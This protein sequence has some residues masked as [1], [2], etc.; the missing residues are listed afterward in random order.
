M[1][2]QPSGWTPPPPPSSQPVLEDDAERERM[3]HARAEVKG[4]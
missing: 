3:A 1:M 2:S 4:V